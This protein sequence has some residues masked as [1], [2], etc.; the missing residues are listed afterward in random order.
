MSEEQPTSVSQY[1]QDTQLS[2]IIETAVNEC[3]KK[4]VKDPKEFFVL[5]FF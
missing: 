2:K 3:Y 4:Q 5:F 1:L